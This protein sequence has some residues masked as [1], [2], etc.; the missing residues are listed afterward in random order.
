MVDH[1]ALLRNS[2]FFA[3]IITQ[4][5][6]SLTMQRTKVKSVTSAEL[7]AQCRYG[8]I[9]SRPV[10]TQDTTKKFKKLLSSKGTKSS[11]FR[12]SYKLNVICQHPECVSSQNWNSRCYF[13]TF[14]RDHWNPKHGVDEALKCKVVSHWSIEKQGGISKVSTEY[15]L[16]DDEFEYIDSTAIS[17]HNF[18]V[19]EPV[20]VAV[21]D[22]NS[23]RFPNTNLDEMT[24][25]ELNDDS[26]VTDSSDLNHSTTT[27]SILSPPTATNKRKRQNPLSPSGDLMYVPNSI[28]FPLS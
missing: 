11:L 8:L 22:S 24:S 17:L 9:T 10:P 19:N 27:H 6:Q 18:D 4:I 25:N 15:R 20:D 3:Q 14:R 13:K 5:E 1:V 16:V 23:N 28:L 7:L 2:L 26:S 21:D 12:D